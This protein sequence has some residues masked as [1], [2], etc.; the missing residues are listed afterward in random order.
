MRNDIQKRRESE[1]GESIPGSHYQRR[2]LGQF[3]GST[4]VS[5]LIIAPNPT[6]WLG[7]GFAQEVFMEAGAIAN[8]AA[9][10]GGEG[11]SIGIEF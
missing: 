4:P 11:F 6:R 10:I 7:Q 1:D 5:G 3:S 8:G 2:F 9:L